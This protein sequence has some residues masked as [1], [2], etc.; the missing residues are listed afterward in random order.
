MRLCVFI[1]RSFFLISVGLGLSSLGVTDPGNFALLFAIVLLLGIRW[2]NGK[3]IFVPD[4]ILVCLPYFWALNA[5]DCFQI[6]WSFMIWA[7]IIAFAAGVG[8][9]WGRWHYMPTKQTEGLGEGLLLAFLSLIC[10]SVFMKW[11]SPWLSLWDYRKINL[12]ALFFFGGIPICQV[13]GA[14]ILFES[15]PVGR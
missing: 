9:F 12:A 5:V 8:V 1:C 4:A 6:Y 2:R 10:F 7:F 3:E 11:A 14:G 13:A 15:E